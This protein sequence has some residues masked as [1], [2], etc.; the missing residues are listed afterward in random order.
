MEAYKEA[1]GERNIK[2]KFTSEWKKMLKKKVSKM[3]N[4]NT[5][6]EN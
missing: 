3:I 1:L 5:N 6:N 4:N 2:G